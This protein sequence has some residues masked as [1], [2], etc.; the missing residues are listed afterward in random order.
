[1]VLIIQLALFSL[2]GLM[3]WQYLPHLPHFQH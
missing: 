1:M 3:R 2:L